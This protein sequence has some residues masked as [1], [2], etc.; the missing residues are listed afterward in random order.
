MGYIN[1][2]K[3][4]THVF[5]FSGGRV[6]QRQDAVLRAPSAE[7]LGGPSQIQHP[8]E[9]AGAGQ[10]KPHAAARQVEPWLSVTLFLLSTNKHGK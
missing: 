2:S 6:L 4:Q 1:L 8:E 9:R 3:S 7:D 10:R 5:V